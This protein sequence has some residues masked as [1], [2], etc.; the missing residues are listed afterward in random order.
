MAKRGRKK[1]DPKDRV[2]VVNISLDQECLD[3]LKEIK[4]TLEDEV[5]FKITHKQAIKAILHR[6]KDRACKQFH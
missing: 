1:M 5:G 2:K 6:H 4:A 3:L